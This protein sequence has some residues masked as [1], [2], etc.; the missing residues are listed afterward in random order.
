MRRVWRILG[1]ASLLSKI[2]GDDSEA[3]GGDTGC[4]LSYVLPEIR[5]GKDHEEGA[6]DTGCNLSIT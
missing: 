1:A 3:G 6:E 2:L 5:I 4:S